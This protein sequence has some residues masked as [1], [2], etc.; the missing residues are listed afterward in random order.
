MQFYFETY[1]CQMNIAESAALRQMLLLRGWSEYSAQCGADS[2]KAAGNLFMDSTRAAQS[3]RLPDLVIINTC[4]VRITAEQRV[5]GRLAYYAS[6]KNK[7]AENNSLKNIFVLVTGCM[8]ERIGESLIEKGADYILGTQ[9]QNVFKSILDEVELYLNKNSVT[10]NSIT[11]NPIVQNYIAHNSIADNSNKNINEGFVFFQNYFE[12]GSFRSL[13]PIMHGCNN[14]C[15]YCSIR[16]RQGSFQ[17]SCRYTL[18][19][20]YAFC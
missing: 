12:Q 9:Q 17:I 16:T 4:S 3:G 15:S 5:I 7:L 18:R 8:A 2:S 6:V 1:G 11:Q 10:Q 19:D 13:V 20:R 14:F